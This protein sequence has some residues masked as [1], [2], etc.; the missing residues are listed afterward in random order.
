MNW[1]LQLSRRL[2]NVEILDCE[3]RNVLKQNNSTEAF[4]Y[5]ECPYIG[6][7]DYYE[8]AFTDKDHEDF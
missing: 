3:F 5:A 4:V 6:T 8:N 7:G 1:I 2:Q